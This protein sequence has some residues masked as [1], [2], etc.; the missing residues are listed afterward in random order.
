MGQFEH[1][2]DRSANAAT[3]KRAVTTCK[4]SLN[5]FKPAGA[6][7]GAEEQAFPWRS[8]REAS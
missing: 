2:Q 4:N 5:Q 8:F 7:S 1:H 6:T 3:V